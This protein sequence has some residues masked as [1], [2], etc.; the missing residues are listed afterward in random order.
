MITDRQFRVDQ[1]GTILRQ[2]RWQWQKQRPPNRPRPRRRPPSRRPSRNRWPW[3]RNRKCRPRPRL[4]L[5]DSLHP[6]QHLTA[7]LSKNSI[8][9][10]GLKYCSLGS[11]RTYDPMAQQAM[12]QPPPANMM[13]PAAPPNNMGMGY[14]G[15][16]PQQDQQSYAPPPSMM[17]PASTAPAAPSPAPVV[18]PPAPVQKGPIPTEHQILQQVFDGLR[19]K[20]LQAAGHPVSEQGLKQW[21][22]VF[23]C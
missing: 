5:T 6:H 21:D 23:Y 20:C 12:Y 13:T 22:S 1:D 3:Y 16:Q 15:Y 10:I 14:G 18:E 19:D 8:G 2:Q 11:F 7:N 4:N 17:T 9:I